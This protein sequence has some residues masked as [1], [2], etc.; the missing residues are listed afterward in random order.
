ME[1]FIRV[2]CAPATND[3]ITLCSLELRSAIDWLKSAPAKFVIYFVAIR[4]KFL[5]PIL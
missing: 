3:L 1:N 2:S 4:Y 5:D